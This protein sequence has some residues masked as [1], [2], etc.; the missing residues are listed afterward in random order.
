M[1]ISKLFT[2]GEGLYNGPR[3]YDSVRT[4]QNYRLGQGTLEDFITAFDGELPFLPVC[5]RMGVVVYSRALEG[6]GTVSE[7]QPFYRMQE[8][9]MRDG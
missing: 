5:Y 1:D 9:R 7:D 2:P 3:P 4:F 6:V 8:W